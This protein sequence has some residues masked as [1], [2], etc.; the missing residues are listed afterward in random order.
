[1]NTENI[2][3][4]FNKII[5]DIVNW[6]LY[7]FTYILIS[8]VVVIVLIWL[9]NAISRNLEKVI[10]KRS[11][12]LH[13]KEAQKRVKT[14]MS[15]GRGIMR[16][17]LWAIFALILLKRI[18]IEIG[19]IIASAGIAGIAIG[20][21]AQELIRDFL[22]GFFV[23]LDNQIRADDIVVINGT[24]G[25]VEK[26]ELRTIRLRDHS[27]VVHIFQH[28]KV[29][30][31]SNMT[32]EW[33]ALVFEIGVAYKEDVDTV[34]AIMKSVGEDL[35]KDSRFSGNILE[36]ISILGV[37]Q[38]ANSSIQLKVRIKTQTGEQWQ[39][40]REYMRR[41]KYAFDKKGIEIP[42]PHTTLYWGEK[43][44]PMDISLQK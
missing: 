12:A 38:F 43:S 26:I 22:A 31:L 4:A 42:F 11:D 3:L 36:P 9:L 19:P 13:D 7:D 23:L 10:L 8:L 2:T 17:I 5:T 41:L 40:R 14:L 32:K 28:G 21:G 27:G 34:I 25:V 1:M 16:L 18:G 39:T 24:T 33:S 30:T 6:L 35:E 15:I 20:F 37:E 44:K 29:N